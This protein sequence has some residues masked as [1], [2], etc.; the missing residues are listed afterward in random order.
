MAQK[1]AGGAISDVIN[2]LVGDSLE[3]TLS[4]L[5]MEGSKVSGGYLVGWKLLITK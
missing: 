4:S 3:E 2:P 5:Q 1:L